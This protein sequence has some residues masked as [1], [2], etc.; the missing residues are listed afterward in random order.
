MHASY[1]LI[2]SCLLLLSWAQRKIAAHSYNLGAAS[3]SPSQ[4]GCASIGDLEQSVS[5]GRR[6]WDFTFSKWVAWDP[7]LPRGRGGV[8]FHYPVGNLVKS[9]IW[10]NL[11]AQLVRSFCSLS[12][13]CVL[14]I[15]VTPGKKEMCVTELGSATSPVTSRRLEKF[16][17]GRDAKRPNRKRNWA[18]RCSE[19]ENRRS[20]QPSPS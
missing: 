4:K 15:S 3:F 7:L 11:F 17:S 14:Q 10:L 19:Q 1:W 5:L 16:N 9:W 8:W 6:G 20:Y 18:Y 13:Q 12:L 2:P